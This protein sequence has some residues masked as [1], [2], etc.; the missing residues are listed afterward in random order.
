MQE[1]FCYF[2]TGCWVE[3]RDQIITTNT[4]TP[5]GTKGD[6]DFN[7]NRLVH[8]WEFVI[9]KSKPIIVLTK[10]DL[11]KWTKITEIAQY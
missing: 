2:K 1:H 11:I 7:I 5:F 9:R 10:T 4:I 6:R 3:L 8:I